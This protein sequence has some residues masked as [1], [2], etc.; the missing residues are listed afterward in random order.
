MPQQHALTATTAWNDG[1]FCDTRPAAPLPSVQLFDGY[2]PMA[3]AGELGVYL[4]ALR[5]YVALK[6]WLL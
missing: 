2:R 4:P 5:N 3:L 1:E 6:P